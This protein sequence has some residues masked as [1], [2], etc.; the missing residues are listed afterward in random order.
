MSERL[1]S[2]A[3]TIHKP[4]GPELSGGEEVIE[5]SSP[6]STAATLYEKVRTAV[7]YQEEHLLRRNAILRILKRYLGS[8]LP[9][10]KMAHNLLKEL[11]WAKYLPNR[12]I[13]LSFAKDLIPIF[14]KYEPLLR[15]IDESSG[16]RDE[17]FSWVLDVMSTEMEYAI[18]PP[19][20][21]EALVSYMYEEM[22][23]RIFWDPKLELGED[24]K[25]LRLYI[26]IHKELLKSN[27]AT[28][29][30]RVMTLYYPDWPGPST[31][32]RVDE[33]TASLDT[34]I[35]MVDYQIKNP[36]TEKLSL[37]IRRKAGLFW[38]INDIIVEHKEDFD[39]V[40]ADPEIMDREVAKI[41]KRRT[42][43]FRKRLRRTI[44]RAV[45][46]LFITKMCLAL[47]LE[48]PYDLL[49]AHATSFM[50]LVVNILFHPFLLGFIAATAT[51]PEKKNTADYISAVRA[52][53]VGVDHELVNIR[54]KRETFGAL[55]KVFSLVY[56]LIFVF[57]Y[58]FIATFLV[59]IGFNVLSTTLFLF[60]LSLVTFFGIRIRS[61]TK[62]VILSN[63]RTG[64][65]GSLFDAFM[66]P[67]VRA[68][69]WLSIKVS[70]VNVFIYFFDFIIESPYK[71]L[72]RFIEGWVSYI[73]EKKEE[74]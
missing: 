12:E 11:I 17:A 51:I 14:I 52:L 46:F 70:K 74:I 29:R 6:A 4:H 72:V 38:V 16:R 21:E 26:G 62:D 73:R 63:I 44:I 35:E 42:K 1:R 61:S 33:V 57:T 28:L 67:L 23:Q 55:S 20:A 24:E 50:P 39:A 18:T 71:V 7:D 60:F 15:W 56:T 10:E 54:V 25:D 64:I 40:L 5:V 36:A 68:G 43:D 3:S 19:V 53:V 27:V 13:P 30:F 31:Q 9:I 2:L 48:V 65:F 34:I 58:V 41:L 59:N 49:I 22:K 37:M 47:I 69:R 45:L 32:A 66:L 8:D